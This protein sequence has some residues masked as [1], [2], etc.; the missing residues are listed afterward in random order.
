LSNYCNSLGNGFSSFED[1]C[2]NKLFEILIE[3]MAL[4]YLWKCLPIADKILLGCSWMGRN[5]SQN[6]HP[7]NAKC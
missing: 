7:S 4:K 5:L 3:S 6:K 1:C 2:F